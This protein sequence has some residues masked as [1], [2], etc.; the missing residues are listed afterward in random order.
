[1]APAFSFDDAGD[2]GKRDA[3]RL[4]YPVTANP[5]GSLGPNLA[6]I[7]LSKFG[8]GVSYAMMR[9]P[10]RL[11]VKDPEGVKG[12]R[13]VANDLKVAQPIVVFDAIQVVRN[14]PFRDG[15]EKC[16]RHDAVELSGAIRLTPI[17]NDE[18]G[19]SVSV[20]PSLHKG[21]APSA[22]KAIRVDLVARTI[23]GIP[24]KV[25]DFHTANYSGI[26]S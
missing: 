6:H 23:G 3:K 20:A 11:S 16:L 5:C 17:L 21:S 25:G 2:A 1:M 15:A 8:V 7:V 22:K 26:R 14:H 18:D 9:A 24:P 19:I 13:G 4:G 10:I 12:I